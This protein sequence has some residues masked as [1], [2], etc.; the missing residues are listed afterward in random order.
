MRCCPLLMVIFRTAVLYITVVVFMRIMGKRQV[1]EL[2]PGEL[3]VTILI[4]EL[5][6]I[7]VQDP[8][9]PVISGVIPIAVLVLCEILMSC[10]SLKFPFLRRLASGKPAIVIEKGRVDEKAL[11]KLRM[12]VD[13][14]IEGLRQNGVFDLKQVSYAIMETNGKLSVLLFD[15][16]SPVTKQDEKIKS[17]DAG[18]PITV[19]SDGRLQRKAIKDRKISMSEIDRELKKKGLS[20]KQVFIMRI[21]DL[22]QFEIIKKEGVK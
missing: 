10:L 5:A 12:S 16:Y 21:D 4:S 11:R 9:R 14:L 3:C 17:R 7:P 20:V 8:D 15:K 19:I 13:D 6:S 22:H 2:Q 1:G 18:V